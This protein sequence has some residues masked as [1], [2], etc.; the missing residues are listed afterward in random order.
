VSTCSERVSNSTSTI[1][2][3]VNPEVN[4]NGEFVNSRHFSEPKKLKEPR[5]HLTFS[6]SK[7]FVTSN[8]CPML[9]D[10]SES[11]VMKRLIPQRSEKH[12]A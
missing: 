8:W 12:S 2:E 6:N 3:Y 9:G 11:E 4:N 5:K 7:T 1:Y 10:I